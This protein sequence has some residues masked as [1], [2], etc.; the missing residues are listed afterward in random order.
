MYDGKDLYFFLDETKLKIEKQ[1]IK[2][3]PLSYVIAENDKYISYYDKS[4]DTFKTIE[5]HNNKITVENDY[6]KI[7]VNIDNIDYYGTNVILTSKITELNTI[8]MKDNK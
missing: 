3:S 7:Y 2:L 5:T 6:Y 8:D 1:E 4:S